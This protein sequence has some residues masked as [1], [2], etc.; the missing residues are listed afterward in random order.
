[1]GFLVTCIFKS[2]LFSD[3]ELADKA[4]YSI[5]KIKKEKLDD[6]KCSPGPDIESQDLFNNV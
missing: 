6:L 4:N 3:W 1:M 5:H 2:W